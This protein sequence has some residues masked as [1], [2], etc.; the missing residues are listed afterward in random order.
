MKK[1]YRDYIERAGWINNPEAKVLAIAYQMDQIEANQMES[2]MESE[3]II[4]LNIRGIPES[5][6]RKAK[7]KAAAEGKSLRA[8]IIEL[9][10][11]WVAE[12]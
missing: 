1:A 8:V 2:K 6:H 4:A 11:R 7:S 10:E 5:L 3:K 9:L 12:R